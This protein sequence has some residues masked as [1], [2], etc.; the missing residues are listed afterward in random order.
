MNAGC[1][2]KR[3]LFFPHNFQI[4]FSISNHCAQSIG[5]SPRTTF[6]NMIT[7]HTPLPI[8]CQT[9]NS[10]SRKIRPCVYVL[11]VVHYTA[12]STTTQC[13]TYL[14]EKDVSSFI[15]HLF[16]DPFLKQQQTRLK[17]FPSMRQHKRNWWQTSFLQD[18]KLIGR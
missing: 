3:F 9:K 8:F 6:M 1:C 18:N 14:V 16:F 13:S 4:E 10:I 2:T 15:K 7:K 17:S 11:Y 5:C 12:N